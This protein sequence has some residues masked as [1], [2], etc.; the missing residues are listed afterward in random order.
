MNDE[1][2]KEGKEYS[3]QNYLAMRKQEEIYQIGNYLKSSENACMAVHLRKIC[4]ELMITL[5]EYRDYKIG[6]LFAAVAIFDRYMYLATQNNIKFKRAK[7]FE[8]SCVCIIL[9]AKFEEPYMPDFTSMCCAL[10]QIKQIKTK[11]QTLRDI[12]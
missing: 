11:P 10:Q 9:A 5:Q 1:G 2:D 4:I 8:I 6:T 12:E 3:K 7:L